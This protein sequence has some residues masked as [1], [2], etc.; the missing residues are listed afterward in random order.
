[1]RYEVILDHG[2]SANRCTI[3]PLA[4]RPDFRIIQ[5]RH[6]EG[7]ALGPFQSPVLLH[8]DGECLTG[9]ATPVSGI[10]TIDC[11]W[12]RLPTL[13]SRLA[14]PLP[15]LVRIPAGFVTAYP[16]TNK[17][18]QDPEGGLATIEAI[19]IAAA[20]L[21]RWDVTLLSRYYFGRRFVE[22]NA[23]RF[24][25]L[26]VTAAAG[27]FPE[28]RLVRDARQRRRDRRMPGALEKEAAAQ[29]PVADRAEARA[30]LEGAFERESSPVGA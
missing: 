9:W 18:G 11:V 12:K 28:F 24:R 7:R 8:P 27:P 19:F 23:A 20:L 30:V 3:A 1:M 15:Q 2:E 21:G 5:V 6:H 16:R 10:A 13:L 14:T 25:E 29:Q 4:E 22:L 26:G 17:H